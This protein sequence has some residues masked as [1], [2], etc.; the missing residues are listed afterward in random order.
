MDFTKKNT[1]LYCYHVPEGID[2]DYLNSIIP[3]YPSLAVDYS[4]PRSYESKFDKKFKATPLRIE[5][6]SSETAIL[7]YEREDDASFVRSSGDTLPEQVIF[8]FS[9]PLAAPFRIEAVSLDGSRTQTILQDERF[10]SNV[11]QLLPYPACY[12]VYATLD[13][14]DGTVYEAQYK[15][16]FGYLDMLDGYTESEG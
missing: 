13:A 4:R 9:H 5:E 10:M 8:E 6:V 1:P 16:E 11:V 12:T 7:L 2:W 15:F 3:V 14:G